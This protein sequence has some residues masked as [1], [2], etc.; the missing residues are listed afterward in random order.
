MGTL[1]GEQRYFDDAARQVLG[2]SARLFHEDTGLFDH[3][4]F[5]HAA[6]Y[7]PV[8]YWGRGAGWMLMSMAE[9]LSVMPERSSGPREGARCSTAKA[10][11]GAVRVQGSTG[12]WHQLLDKTDSYLETSA[13]A[14]FTFAIARGVNRGWIP[15][16]YA[17]GG[18]DGMA[19]RRHAR[20]GRRQHRRHLREHDRRGRRRSTT[21]TGRRTS[22]R[23]R[24]TAP[25][26]WPAPRSCRWSRHVQHQP[27]E[28]HVL[29]PGQEV[30]AAAGG[31]RPQ[32]LRRGVAV[33][34]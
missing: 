18:T 24:G 29:L 11:Q 27:D 7:D 19:R 14:M 21:T 20:A 4:W 22:P 25:C 23:C 10:V 3:T 9:L 28:Q 32:P 17:P 26:S 1:T 12:L 8:F 33:D 30:T 2:M 13:T 6:P 15:A 5:E 34:W 16:V 31:L